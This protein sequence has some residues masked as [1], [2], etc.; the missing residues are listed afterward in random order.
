MAS[1]PPPPPKPWETRRIPGTGPGPGPG[2]TFQDFR[3]VVGE[4]DICPAPL[5]REQ[6]L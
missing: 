4:K 5:V 6:S 1:Q 2:P 3:S